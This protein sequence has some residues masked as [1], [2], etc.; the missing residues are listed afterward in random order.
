MANSKIEMSCPIDENVKRYGTMTVTTCSI[1]IHPAGLLADPAK[2]AREREKEE[3]V[4]QA[5]ERL[6]EERRK[7]LEELREQQRIAQVQFQIR[8][9]IHIMIMIHNFF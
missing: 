8:F 5:R 4:R 6:N 3:R 2:I 7:K 1:C 9:L